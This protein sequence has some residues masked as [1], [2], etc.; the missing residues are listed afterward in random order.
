MENVLFHVSKRFSDGGHKIIMV[1]IDETISR[2][3]SGHRRTYDMAKPIPE[4]IKI[5]NDLY[6]QGHYIIMWTARG[7]SEERHKLGS[8]PLPR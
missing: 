7:S 3:A 5:V 2:Y 8:P 1:D 4:A 6:D